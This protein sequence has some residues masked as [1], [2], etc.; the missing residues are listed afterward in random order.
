M[1]DAEKAAV[2]RPEQ[3]EF[4]R[5]SFRAL[6]ATNPNYFGNS[7]ELGFEPIEPKAGDDSYEELACVSY[8]PSRDRIE[9]TVD[10]KRS[11]GYLGG[12]CTAG[13]FEHVRFY[14]DYGSG[15]EDAGVAGINVHDIPVGKDCEGQPTHP[16]SYV[17]GVDYMP[18]RKWCSAPVLPLV[19]AILSWNLAPPAGQPDWKPAWGD[20]RECRVQITPRKVVFA[21][22]AE[23]FSKEVLAEIPSL[24]LQE[25][26]SPSPDPG[27]FEPLSLDRLAHDYAGRDVPPHRFAFEYL[28]RAASASINPVSLADSAATAA[29]AGLNAGEILKVVQNTSG[30]T[31]YEELE[32]VGLDEAKQSLVATFTVKLSSGYS[33]PPCSAGSTEYVGFWADWDDQCELEYLGTVKVTVHDYQDIRKGLC[34]AATLPVDLGAFRKHCKT[35]ALRRVKAVLSWNAPPSTTD[36][37]ALPV[38]GNAIERHVQ[39]APG[40][41]YDGKARFTI[42]GGVAA[43]NVDLGT[44][45]TKPGAVLGTSFAL[46]DDCPFAGLIVLHGPNDPAL[47]GHQYRI[48]ATNAD[49]GGSHLVTA[50]FWAVT[51]GG[52]NVKVTPDPIN[53]W[54]PWPTWVTNTEGVLGVDSPGGDERWDFTLELDAPGNVVATARVQ[55]DSTLKNVADLSDTVNAGD[56]TLFTAGACKQPHGPLHGKFVARDRFFH[57]WSIEVIGG[58]GGP[59]PAI[60]LT[61]GP[62]AISTGTPTPFSGIPFT[63]DFSDPMIA[64]CGY[65]VR[66]RITDRAI[67]DSAGFGRSVP[68]DRGICLE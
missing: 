20:V 3:A 29:K 58:P 31:T 65:D 47:A 56:L 52:F 45:L 48:R 11:F 33:G 39:I 68:V 35:A 63:L 18:K 55:M 43:Q 4:T 38:W 32:C 1:A 42:V 27:P 61:T 51:S 67:V 25:P 46:P 9:A 21:D 66:L 60:P 26:P 22:L 13:S 7:P 64:P 23:K 2:G 6:L 49:F 59:I 19:R 17:C 12:L 24:A 50:P 14:V 36:P 15:W 44:G 8:S 10:V 54:A 37:N 16:L 5:L 40:Q 41:P 53:G 30:N 57:S 28:T 34:Y 62:P